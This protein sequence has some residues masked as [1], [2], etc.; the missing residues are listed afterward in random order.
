MKIEVTQ[1]VRLR[2]VS[3][4]ARRLGCSESH[5]SRVLKGER[6]AGPKLAKK[7]KKLGVAPAV[8]V[9]KI[10]QVDKADLVDA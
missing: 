1:S 2:N 8:G 3:A 4:F 7:L 9:G 5:L 6:L 10:D